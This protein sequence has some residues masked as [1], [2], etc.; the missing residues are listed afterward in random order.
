MCVSVSLLTPFVFHHMDYYLLLIPLA[1][2]NNHDKQILEI[3]SENLLIQNFRI[4][5]ISPA[6]I[7]MQLLK[8]NM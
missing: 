7:S 4:P 6:F 5:V 1:D 8:A 2:V 3:L